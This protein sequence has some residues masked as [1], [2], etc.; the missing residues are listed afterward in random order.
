MV[1]EVGGSERAANQIVESQSLGA[2]LGPWLSNGASSTESSLQGNFSL[3]LSVCVFGH[4]GFEGV[5]PKL[6][7]QAE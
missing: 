1:S 4:G 6:W 5:L 2:L 3:S 7:F